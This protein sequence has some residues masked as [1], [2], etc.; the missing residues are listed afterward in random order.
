MSFSK[1][2]YLN[3]LH[4]KDVCVIRSLLNI[5]LTI[6]L[7]SPSLYAQYNIVDWGAYLSDDGTGWNFADD[8]LIDDIKVDNKNPENI[9][10]VGRTRSSI[11]TSAAC[12]G[13]LLSYGKGDVMIAKYN[14][15]GELLWSRYLGNKKKTDYGYSLA[16]DYDDDGNTIVYVAGEMKTNGIIPEAIVCDGGDTPFRATPVGSWDGFIAKYDQKGDLQRWT[17]FGGT[18][19]LSEKVDQVL[20]IAVY[21][22]TVYVT[23]YTESVDLHKGA[24]HVDDTSFEGAGD[25]F[26]A[27]FSADL[28]SL[29][30]FT[31]IGGPGKDRCHG[32]SIYQ[33]GVGTPDIFV[34]GTTPSATGIAIGSGF[35]FTIGGDLDGFVGKWEDDDL[36]GIYTKTWCT[37]IGGNGI[38]RARDMDVDTYG[39]I[40]LIGQTNSGNLVWANGYDNTHNGQN[41]AFVIK[42]PNAGGY[43]IWGTYFGGYADEESVGL[44]WRKGAEKDHVLISGI[45]YSSQKESCLPNPN[46]DTFSVY[47]LKDPLM[48]YI[49]GKTGLNYCPGTVGDAFIAELTDAAIGQTLV[50]STF[51]GGSGNEV[52]GENQLSYNPSF[53]LSKYGEMYIAFNSRSIDIAPQLGTAIH[54]LYGSY[55]GGIDGVLA[56]FI[57]STSSHHLCNEFRETPTAHNPFFNTSYLRET[58]HVYPNPSGGLF[59]IEFAAEVKAPLTYLIFDIRG[60]AVHSGNTF[61]NEGINSIAVDLHEQPTGLYVIQINYQGITNRA[62]LFRQ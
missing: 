39:N 18:D 38:E 59:N 5:G 57:D 7:T 29:E 20:G 46:P 25:G 43:P 42:I 53:S 54:K 36:N 17:Y 30:F 31:Y 44:A 2:L 41:D 34:D 26:L 55:H 61:V 56:R 27:A 4:Y 19:T 60:V 37:Y 15:C 50:F 28:H 14:Q 21:N 3:L 51:I 9:Y 33:K 10:V 6:L 58:L 35:D 11:G 16:L 8:E 62:K 52:N 22:H 1:K 49:N 23:G 47:P 24:L 45:T 32:I 40:M 12:Q 48:S 13:N